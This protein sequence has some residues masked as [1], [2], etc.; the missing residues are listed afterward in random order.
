MKLGSSAISNASRGRTEL[1][2]DVSGRRSRSG[3]RRHLDIDRIKSPCSRGEERR[4]LVDGADPT[5]EDIELP[6]G[7]RLARKNTKP[8]PVNSALANGAKCEP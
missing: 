3:F 1:R 4:Q 8:V 6:W 2:R 7:G 5:L